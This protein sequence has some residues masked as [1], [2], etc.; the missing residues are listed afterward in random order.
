MAKTGMPAFYSHIVL[1]HAGSYKDFMSKLTTNYPE[2]QVRFVKKVAIHYYVLQLED[3]SPEG[4]MVTKQQIYDL[5]IMAL[6]EEFSSYVFFKNT[7][8]YNNVLKR[9]CNAD[10]NEN[11]VYD[12][13]QHMM[14]PFEKSKVLDLT[15]AK[16]LK[17][18]E[19]NEKNEESITTYYSTE[20]INSMETL[21]K[22]FPLDKVEVDNEEKVVSELIKDKTWVVGIH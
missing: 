5:P 20:I 2:L 4:K 13:M 14:T 21:N 16:Q 6:R 10:K 3:H 1:V 22:I 19:I 8:S 17:I 12:F 15:E 18:T 11:A 9:M 7:R